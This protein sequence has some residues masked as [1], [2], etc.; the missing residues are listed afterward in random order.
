MNPHIINVQPWRDAV[1]L[2]IVT[3]VE[4]GDVQAATDE[5]MGVLEELLAGE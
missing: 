4:G 1:G 3:S 5:A 2:V